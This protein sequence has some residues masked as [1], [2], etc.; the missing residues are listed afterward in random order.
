EVLGLLSARDALARRL[1]K[2]DP[3][4]RDHR[5]ARGASRAGSLQL[6]EEQRPL[7]TRRTIR[8]I[9]F[10][11]LRQAQTAFLPSKMEGGEP[12]ST[13]S[14][15]EPLCGGGR[16]AGS[17]E[18]WWNRPAGELKRTI[19]RISPRRRI[20]IGE[21]AAVRGIPGMATEA[22]AAANATEEPSK[23]TTRGAGAN[24]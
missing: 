24:L 23:L 17:R 10:R 13:R 18:G 19:Y 8:P 1:S 7:P 15:M 16:S 3:T 21:I 2:P 11:A 12:G 14:R 9:L 20:G 6:A 22:A 5:Y 4:R